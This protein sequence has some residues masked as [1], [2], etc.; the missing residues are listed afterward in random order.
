VLA[1]RIG[2]VSCVHIVYVLAQMRPHLSLVQNVDIRTS[3][4]VRVRG[5]RLTSINA[6]FCACL[7]DLGRHIVDEHI[8]NVDSLFASAAVI[9]IIQ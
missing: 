6:I 2:L 3:I 8:F 7:F 9:I 1:Y 5:A 4:G